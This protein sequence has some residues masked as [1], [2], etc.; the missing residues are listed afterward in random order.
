MTKRNYR[1]MAKEIY[2]F[3][4]ERELWQDCCIYFNGKAWASKDMWGGKHGREIGEKLYE[5]ENM[6]P[7][8]YF[9][10][11]DP[12]TLSMSF[13]GELYRVMNAF[14]EDGLWVKWHDEFH[15]LFDKYEG[16]I[17]QGNSWNFTFI[18]D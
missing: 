9:E 6:N 11:G 16:Y 12:D 1:A 7:C 8:D 2:W 5:Y 18:E 13:E 14:W 17:E 3:C 15:N 4:I 10:Y